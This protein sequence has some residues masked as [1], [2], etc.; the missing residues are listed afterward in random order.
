MS[1]DLPASIERELEKY[2]QSEHISPSEAAVKFIQSGLKSSRRKTTHEVT[3]ADLETLRQN[4]PIFAFLEN[5][6]DNVIDGMEAASKQVRAER[7]TPR[8]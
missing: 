6:P 5:L 4:V 2:A 1:F 3:E 8:G 7:F